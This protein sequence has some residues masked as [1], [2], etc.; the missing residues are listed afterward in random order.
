MSHEKSKFYKCDQCDYKTPR[1]N[2]IRRHMN[3]VHFDIR[4]WQCWQCPRRFK[5]G[6]AL[7]KHLVNVHKVNF[8]LKLILR[9]SCQTWLKQC[10][11]F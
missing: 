3:D 10:F 11:E 7:N 1:R 2:C 9:F 8:I 4:K 5:C 6:S